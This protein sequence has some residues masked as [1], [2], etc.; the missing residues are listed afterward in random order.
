MRANALAQT[1]HISKLCDQGK[2]SR[3]KGT[4]RVLPGS[5]RT[6]SQPNSKNQGHNK[7]ESKGAASNNASDVRGAYF[8]AANPTAK[9]PMNMGKDSNPVVA[10]AGTKFATG[11]R[12]NR[13]AG[14]RRERFCAC[15]LCGVRRN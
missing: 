13:P 15:R 10:V 5:I 9:C 1:A 4:K 14:V 3:S 2:Y 6:R 11:E 7:S 8:L 12:R